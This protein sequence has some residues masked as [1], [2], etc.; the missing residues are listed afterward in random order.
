VD[1]AKELVKLYGQKFDLLQPDSAAAA[2]SSSASGPS[3]ATIKA[4]EDLKG[5]ISNHLQVKRPAQ[6]SCLL[7]AARVGCRA[8]EGGKQLQAVLLA[9]CVHHGGPSAGCCYV[10]TGRS[11]A[12]RGAHS[13]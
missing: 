12:G 11:P 13:C 8:A 2:N 1:S 7:F 4:L 10:Q 3:A 6:L 9:G 5:V